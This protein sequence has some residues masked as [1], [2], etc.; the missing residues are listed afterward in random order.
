[1]KKMLANG[2]MGISQHFTKVMDPPLTQRLMTSIVK[3]YIKAITHS[4]LSEIMEVTNE[5]GSYLKSKTACNADAL[6]FDKNKTISFKLS[7]ICV[8]LTLSQL[9]V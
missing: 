9:E 4:L 2:Q 1:M 3:S 8:N 5:S 6:L 7:N